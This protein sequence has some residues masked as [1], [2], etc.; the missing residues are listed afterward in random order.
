MEMVRDILPAPGATDIPEPAVEE[1]V[2]ISMGGPIGQD[3][4]AEAIQRLQRYKEGKTNL[5]QRVVQD[6]QWYKLRHWE[7]M[8]KG[9]K[10]DNASN[11]AP[12]SAWLFNAIANKHAD[13]M[14]NYPEPVVLPGRS[15]TRTAQRPSRPFCRSSWSATISTRPI[16]T[17]GGRN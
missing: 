17:T 9:D 12:A 4:I 16:P 13:A 10:N 6:E 5:E 3:E 15:W 8:R 2:E 1:T 11:P 7:V 14:D